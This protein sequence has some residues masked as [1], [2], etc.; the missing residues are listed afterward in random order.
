M[1]T[2][3]LFAR[4]QVLIDQARNPDQMLAD[5]PADR[6]DVLDELDMVIESLRWD[7]LND[8]GGRANPVSDR[9]RVLLTAFRRA[10]M[11]AVAAI[12]QYLKDATPSNKR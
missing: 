8:I 3:Q 11:L 1:T 4:A 10:L 9:D 2:A 5:R 6:P 12:D 7:V